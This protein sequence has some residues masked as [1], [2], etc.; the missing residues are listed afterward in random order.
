M[1]YMHGKEVIHGDL[2]CANILVSPEK[3]AWL[4]DFGMSKGTGVLTSIGLKS[5]GCQFWMSPERLAA[6]DGVPTRTKKDDVHSFGITIM[7]VSLLL[8]IGYVYFTTN[9]AVQALDGKVPFDSN[10]R[11]TVFYEGRMD[12]SLQ[13][14][15]GERTGYLV[16]VAKDCWQ[17]S[18]D[19]RPDFEE[20]KERLERGIEASAS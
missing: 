7:E 1:A 3:R 18:P 5:A 11:T 9:L 10:I 20:V 16:D 13:P 6:D 8:C 15:C 19:A 2:R 14:D 17:F 4:C 12:G